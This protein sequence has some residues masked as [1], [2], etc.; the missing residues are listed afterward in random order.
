MPDYYEIVKKPMDL[1]TMMKKLRAHAYQDRRSFQADLD[2]I[3]ANCYLYNAETVRCLL[4]SRQR[5]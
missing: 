3:Y 5:V 1:S 2:L 4:M